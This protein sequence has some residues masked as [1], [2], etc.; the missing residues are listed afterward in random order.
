MLVLNVSENQTFDKYV[1]PTLQHVRAEKIVS[2]IWDYDYTVWKPEP[3]EITNRLGWLRIVNEMEKSEPDLVL[4]T[5]SVRQ[6]GYTHVV[7]LGMGGSSLATDVF[8]RIFDKGDDYL[9]LS[10]LDSTDPDAVQNCL[11]GHDL[12]Y[13]LFIVATKSGG[14]SETLSFFKFFYNRYLDFVDADQAGQHFVAITDPGSKLAILAETL[15]FRKTFL[16]DSTIGGRFSVLSYFGLVP[17]ALMGID[18]HKL[19]SRARIM[20]DQCGATR[21]DETNPSVLLGGTL[22]ALALKNINKVTF[23]SSVKLNPFGDW[24]EQLIAESTGKEG[25]GILPVVNE[26]LGLPL[27]YGTDRVFIV[28]HLIFEV[29]CDEALDMLLNANFQVVHLVLEDLYDLGA[30]FF[31]WEMATAIIGHCLSIQPFDQPNVEMA[32]HLAR[33]SID[34]YQKTGNLTQGEYA[35]V[36][37]N[38]LQKF[39]SAVQ[40][41]DY[42]SIQAYIAPEPEVNQVLMELQLYIR[43]LTGVPVTIGYGPR[44][45]HSTGQLHKGDGGNGLF[46]QLVSDNE[47]DL[48]I[49]DE[50]G[51]S[52]SSISFGVLKKAQAF[53]DYQAL[54]EVNRRI[55]RYLVRG[56][57]PEVIRSLMGK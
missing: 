28:Q 47:T 45:L 49:P 7:L 30:L 25:K 21:I 11:T 9:Q 3:T 38:T 5:D 23:I 55:I 20:M 57:I 52:L 12:A 36:S 35:T 6:D 41:G 10:I 19:L 50:P 24:V 42:V 33:A 26:P 43:H 14:T 22:G 15:H 46:I 16:N 34:E 56:H 39:L 8:Q 17:A 29:E 31:L 2:R 51:Q 40:P 27:E 53:G 1:I 44:F 18:I 13:T 32:K 37:A 54:K 4:F 48:P